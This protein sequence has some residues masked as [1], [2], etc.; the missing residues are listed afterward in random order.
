ML[1]IL[2]KMKWDF[3]LHEYQGIEY[4]IGEPNGLHITSKL[5][6]LVSLSNDLDMSGYKKVSLV[7]G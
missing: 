3:M 5:R 7:A 4:L 1:A 6:T 2:Q